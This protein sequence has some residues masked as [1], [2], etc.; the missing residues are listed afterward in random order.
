MSKGDIIVLILVYAF[1][2]CAYCLG[3]F[4]TNRAKRRIAEMEKVDHAEERF[5]ELMKEIQQFSKKGK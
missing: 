2:I 3:T 1:V 4:A 5:A